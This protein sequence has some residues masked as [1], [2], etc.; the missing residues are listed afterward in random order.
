MVIYNNQVLDGADER[1]LAWH[2][3]CHV[4]AGDYPGMGTNMDCL[5]T[6]AINNRSAWIA[7][8]LAKARARYLA[9]LEEEP[10]KKEESKE[11]LELMLKIAIAKLAERERLIE[12][13][14]ECILVL[15][16]DSMV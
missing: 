16:R 4:L 10:V 12:S 14:C 6:D 5:D 15:Q 3:T 13:L 2:E 8:Q 11:R 1:Q 7:D 9:E